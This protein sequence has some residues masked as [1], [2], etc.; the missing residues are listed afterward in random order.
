MIVG[1]GVDLVKPARIKEMIER[2]GDRFLQ[3]VFTPKELEDCLGKANQNEKLAARFAAKEA[4]VKAIGIGMRNGITWLDIEIRNDGMGKPEVNT[5]GKCKQ[6][7]Q[8]LNVGV[9]HVSLSHVNEIAVAMIILE[10]SLH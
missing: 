9:V 5:H 1:V 7:L 3:R 8:I 2:H 4:M 10:K 6:M